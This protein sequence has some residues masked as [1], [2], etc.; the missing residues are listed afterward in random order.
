MPFAG[1]V[2]QP[3]S[4]HCRQ[5]PFAKLKFLPMIVLKCIYLYILHVTYNIGCLLLLNFNNQENRGS[6][7]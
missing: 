1:T 5:A 6:E 4:K 7:N 2:G 3:Y